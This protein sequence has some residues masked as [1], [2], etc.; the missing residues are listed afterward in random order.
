[1]FIFF[2]VKLLYVVSCGKRYIYPN[3]LHLTEKNSNS[4][5]TKLEKLDHEISL[6]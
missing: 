6:K 5:Y 1:M 2:S 4:P 3:I